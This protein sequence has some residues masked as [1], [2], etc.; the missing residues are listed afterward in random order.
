MNRLAS[1]TCSALQM[2]AQNVRT[3]QCKNL[4]DIGLSKVKQGEVVRVL[5]TLLEGKNM[6]TFI[7][8]VGRV[9]TG[10]TDRATEIT[11]YTS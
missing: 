2:S 3:T 10:E 5:C 4:K 1:D 7:A 11:L 8:P 6:N 9:Q